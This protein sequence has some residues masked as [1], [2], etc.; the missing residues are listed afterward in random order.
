MLGGT[1]KLERKEEANPRNVQYAYHKMCSM[2]TTKC[3]VCLPQNVQYAY[4]KMWWYKR[5]WWFVCVT[6][7]WE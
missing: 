7:W 6:Q 3:A 2:L 4:H 5:F 1:R